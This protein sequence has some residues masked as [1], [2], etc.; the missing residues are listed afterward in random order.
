[1]KFN[2]WGKIS[3]F[4]SLGFIAVVLWYMFLFVPKRNDLEKIRDKQKVIQTQYNQLLENYSLAMMGSA[5]KLEISRKCIDILDNLPS[6]EDISSVLSQILKI[7][8]GKDIRIIS[9]SPHEV[10]FSNNQDS[11]RKAQLQK[12]HLDITL[13]GRFINIGQYLFDLTNLP[14]FAGY[15]KIEI[16]TSEEIYPKTTAE[17]TCVLL[18]LNNAA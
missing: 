9:V 16:R 10:S 6:K 5:K 8:Q 12:I 7:G 1:M 15:S 2:I 13:E 18:F 11:K 3:F 14:F 4:I 17:I